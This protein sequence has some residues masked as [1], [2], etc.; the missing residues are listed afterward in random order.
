MTGTRWE[1]EVSGAKVQACD[2]SAEARVVWG[3]SLG[4]SGTLGPGGSQDSQ[5]SPHGDLILLT[6]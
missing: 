2:M 6:A 4:T 1:L 3:L 5:W